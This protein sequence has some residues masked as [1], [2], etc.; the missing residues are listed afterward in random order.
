[1]RTNAIMK[2]AFLGPAQ[3]RV[4]VQK[5]ANLLALIY[6]NRGKK[7]N[8]REAAGLHFPDTRAPR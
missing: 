6:P 8:A 3:Q 2:R 5:P 7:A 1:M 4:P